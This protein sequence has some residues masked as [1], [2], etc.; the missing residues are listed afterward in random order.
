MSKIGSSTTKFEVEKFNGKGNFGLWK[1]RVKELLGQQG[2]HKTL[3]NKVIYNMID[4]ETVTGLWSTL[5]IL[6][7]TKS[8]SNKLYLKKQLYGLRMKENTTVLEHL[9]FFNKVISEL[10]PVD[11]K[12]DEE[13]KTLIFLSSLP[14]SYDHIITIMLYGKKT[15]ILDEVMSTLLSNEISKKPN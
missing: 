6:Y 10:L 1:K 13:D 2:L 9:N 15:L 12:I 4:E 14:E 5:E 7:M 11:V 8:L 3:Q